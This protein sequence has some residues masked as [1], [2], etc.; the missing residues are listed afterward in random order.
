MKSDIHA[1]QL[2]ECQNKLPC[3]KYDFVA[4]LQAR[5]AEA[6]MVRW[7][8]VLPF[9]GILVGTAFVNNVE[10]LILGMPF[11]LAWIVGWV[12]IGAAI[13]AIIYASD[14]ENA[15]GEEEAGR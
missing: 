4:A 6:V 5:D 10:P 11:V 12:V 8:A 13:M 2:W 9:L 14:P 3:Q 7:L 15:A 1:W